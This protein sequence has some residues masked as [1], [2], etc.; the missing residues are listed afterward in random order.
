MF[1][2]VSVALAT[3]FRD[4]QLDVEGARRLV[5]FVL[6]QGV[7]GIVPTGCTG[8]AG[9]L[10][11]EERITFWRL[12]VEEAKGRAFV[13]AGSGTND[14]R[15][16]IERT[17]TAM[18][19]GVDGCMLISPY[20][21]KPSQE[22][23]LHHYRTVAD[24]VD[25]PLV[26]YN[27]PGRTGVNILPRT[28]LSLADHPGIVAV[29]EASGSVDQVT[30]IL[31]GEKDLAVLSGDDTLTLPML[32]AGATGVVSVAGHVAGEELVAM[33]AAHGEGR[34][35]EAARIHRR[36]F[37]LVQALF[38]ESSPGPLKALLAHLGILE[39][40]LRAPLVP[41]GEAVARKVI[42]ELDRADTGALR[43]ASALRS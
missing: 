2:G 39:N 28:T 24:E 9:C 42:H 6:D 20:Y 38:S 25:I 3:P 15:T 10:D 16:T 23:L 31:C 22:G 17:R 21:N 34:W 19:T 14:T 41:V 8:E 1:E 33:L 12:C 18:G 36:L 43:L 5:R 35:E 11:A 13:L 27:V 29:K 7:D 30:E 32:A 37:P 40:E 4:G 26:I